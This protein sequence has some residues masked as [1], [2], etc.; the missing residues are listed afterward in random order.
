MRISEDVNLKCKP[1]Y[2][3]A[4]N[5][6]N[7]V[8]RRRW[9]ARDVRVTVAK[10]TGA[11]KIEAGWS[12]GRTSHSGVMHRAAQASRTCWHEYMRR[13]ELESQRVLS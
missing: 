1:S 9:R 5:G 2:L 8:V 10:A 6:T 4:D 13:R 7:F 3:S 12:N 11:V